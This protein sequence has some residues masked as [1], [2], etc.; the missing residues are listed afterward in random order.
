MRGPVTNPF[1]HEIGL[2]KDVIGAVRG[3]LGLAAI[4]WA[5]RRAGCCRC[6]WAICAP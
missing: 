5:W 1:Y 2:S 3:T 6:G 4:F